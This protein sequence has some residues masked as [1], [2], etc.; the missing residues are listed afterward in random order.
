M[1]RPAP[2]VAFIIPTFRR[3][4]R[5]IEAIESARAQEGIA[6]EV[7]V[8][9]DAPEASTRPL[10][11]ARYADCAEVRVLASGGLGVAGARNLGVAHSTAP[12][13]A[14]LD[15]DDLALPARARLQVAALEAAPEAGMCL[16][17]G[18]LRKGG[19]RFS[20]T[21]GWRWATDLAS[22][23]H[24]AYA[25]PSTTLFRREALRAVPYS[26]AYRAFEDC[27]LLM[28]YYA[29]GRT[30][31]VV[32][33]PIVLYDDRRTAST[34]PRPS[35]QRMSEQRMSEQRALMDACMAQAIEEHWM[36]LPAAARRAMPLGPTMHRRL[37]AHAWRRGR[38][39]QARQHAFA[40]WRARPWRAT[41]LKWLARTWFTTPPATEPRP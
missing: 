36:P 10:L 13:L 38:R 27:E 31:V 22:V 23:F 32:P 16:G 34:G 3:P 18:R 8:V 2:E 25:V 30:A 26:T 9:D 1:S 39:H 29:G 37:A 40:W 15:D 21:R 14:I 19:G 28:R 17:D 35:E 24:G 6:V 7:V 41:P 12:Y 20:E 11:D 33:E 5:V 4:E